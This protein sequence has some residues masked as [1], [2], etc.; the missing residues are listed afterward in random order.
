MKVVV[1]DDAGEV[2]DGIRLCVS[3]RWP[4]CTVL[5]A[6]DGKSGLRLVET[7]GPD[8]VVLDLVLVDGSGLDL[9]REMRAVSDV[10][11]ITVTARGDEM[12]CVKS[13][14]YGADDCI[15]RPF[16]DAELLARMRAVLRRSHARDLNGDQRVVRAGR[17]TIDLESGRAQVDGAETELS[18]TE[19]KLLS[20]LIRNAGKVLS[21]QVLAVNV[22]GRTYVEAS[23]IKMCVR[24]LRIKLRDDMEAP[25]IIR[26]FR[27]RGYSFEPAP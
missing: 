3:N 18:A 21:T 8:V 23:A 26:S 13:L 19:W 1:I 15:A 27:G 24:R 20:F 7:E 2:V 4:D 9:L 10:P 11:V 12:S 22:W 14:E 6:P 25:R 5:S 16:S 17:L